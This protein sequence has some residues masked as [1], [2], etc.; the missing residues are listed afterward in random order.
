MK[1]KRLD[2]I[3]VQPGG[4]PTSHWHWHKR[5]PNGRILCHGETHTTWRDAA[6]AARRANFGCSYELTVRN[7]ED[8]GVKHYEQMVD[9]ECTVLKTP[10]VAAVEIEGQGK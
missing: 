2:R 10:G 3:E 7:E 6:R 4:I 8:S 1:P 9:G 5:A